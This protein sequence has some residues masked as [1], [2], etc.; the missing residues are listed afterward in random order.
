MARMGMHH[1]RAEWFEEAFFK[2][3]V[4]DGSIYLVAD[5]AQVAIDYQEKSDNSRDGRA[6]GG[7]EAGLT[8]RRE[9]LG[10]VVR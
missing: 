1:T 9:P 2:E 8:N 4:V 3:L 10:R 7:G 6:A 5:Q